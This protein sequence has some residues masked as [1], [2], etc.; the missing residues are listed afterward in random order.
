MRHGGHELPCIHNHTHLQFKNK[1]NVCGGGG[2]GGVFFLGG[3]GGG[4]TG[5]FF[6]LLSCS[7]F[8]H[9][10]PSPSRCDS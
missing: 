10:P 5:S 8:L 3:G 2:G 9:P 1:I 4:G 6:G 7:S